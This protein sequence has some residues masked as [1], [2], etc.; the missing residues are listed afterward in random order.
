MT[1]QTKFICAF[2]A[3]VAFIF[4]GIA[5][6]F[7]SPDSFDREKA[8]RMAA[9]AKVQEPWAK[10]EILMKDRGPT[11][12]AW[13]ADTEISSRFYGEAK[14]ALEGALN[15]RS[16]PALDYACKD[17]IDAVILSDFTNKHCPS[18]S[19]K[20]TEKLLGFAQTDAKYQGLPEPTLASVAELA[21]KHGGNYTPQAWVFESVNDRV[22]FEHELAPS[23][24]PLAYW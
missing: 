7:N 9:A 3:V 10:Y 6:V 12:F 14:S 20:K 16:Q 22:E 24:T 19:L 5:W 11:A 1:Y 17:Y 18:I 23:R 13:E 4:G 21:R 8:D 15:E 2:V